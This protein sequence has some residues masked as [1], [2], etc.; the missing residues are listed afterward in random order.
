MEFLSYNL[1]RFTRFNVLF[2]SELP[3]LQN[4]K[5]DVYDLLRNMLMDI[6]DLNRAQVVDPLHEPLYDLLPLDKVYI[7]PQATDTL[8]SIIDEIGAHDEN[9]LLFRHQCW[10][11]VVEAIKQV[12]DRFGSVDEFAFLDILQSNNDFSLAIPSLNA[13]YKKLPWMRAVAPLAEADREFR[14]HVMHRSLNS[15][16]TD[17]SAYWKVVMSAR[18]EGGDKSYPHLSNVV[19]ALMSMPFANAPVERVFSQLRLIKSD[20]RNSMKEETLS[21]LLHTKCAIQDMKKINPDSMPNQNSLS[22]RTCID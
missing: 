2:Q 6:M 11:F 22:P 9:V 5:E 1:D 13:V 17:V 14:M 20:R 10:E 16:I 21:A 3:L 12:R 7:V 19:A 18:T 8:S 15:D 4:L